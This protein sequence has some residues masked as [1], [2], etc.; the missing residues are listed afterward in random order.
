[1][2]GVCA[3]I[4]VSKIYFW[5]ALKIDLFCSNVM[6]ELS[7]KSIS[8]VIVHIGLS[9]SRHADILLLYKLHLNK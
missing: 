3:F 1:M 2:S 4:L 6:F 8:V 9:E 5:T 7:S